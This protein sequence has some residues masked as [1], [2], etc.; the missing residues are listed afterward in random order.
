MIHRAVVTA[1]GRLRLADGRTFGT[2]SG[3]ARFLAGYEV[4]G[5]RTWARARDGVRSAA[6]RDRLSSES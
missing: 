2:P 5:W 1:E 4:N 6:L 3:A